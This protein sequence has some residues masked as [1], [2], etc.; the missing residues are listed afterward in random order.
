MLSLF[1]RAH[2]ARA[3]LPRALCITLALSTPASHAQS[4]ASSKP[5]TA[6]VSSTTAQP[7]TPG[8]PEPASG[9][10]LRYCSAFANYQRLNQQAITPWRSS[11]DA[12]LQARGWRE[13]AMAARANPPEAAAKTSTPLP[14]C[15]AGVASNNGDQP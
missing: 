7:I 12:V 8:T 1:D 14:P 9:I 2:R 6:P 5:D 13:L 11:N 10:R 15:P 4:A 3:W